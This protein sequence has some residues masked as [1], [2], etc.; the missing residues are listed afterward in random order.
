MA[1]ISKAD[2]EQATRIIRKHLQEKIEGWE[3]ANG[4]I[5]QEF[6]KA[7]QEQVRK[8]TQYDKTIKRLEKL[9]QQAKEI[10]REMDLQ[11]KAL[12]ERLGCGEYCYDV[13]SVLEKQIKARQKA[14]L[15]LRFPELGEM[16][17]RKDGVADEI[18]L[19][20]THEELASFVKGV[21][22]GS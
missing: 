1:R 5:M 8:E 13:E 17:K 15:T 4:D 2:R 19:M 20:T 3:R 12:R 21:L 22:N 7:A 18:F 10:N 16:G 9:A 6:L 11:K 14:L